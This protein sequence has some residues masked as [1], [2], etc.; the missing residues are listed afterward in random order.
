MKPFGRET[1]HLAARD[2]GLTQNLRRPLTCHYWKIFPEG[3]L[4]LLLHTHI[5]G[6]Y[7]L[8]SS[9]LTV[10]F[11]LL[12]LLST[13]TKNPLEDRNPEA[14]LVFVFSSHLPQTRRKRLDV[15]LC[16]QSSKSLSAQRHCPVKVC[17][18]LSTCASHGP[19]AVWSRFAVIA[20]YSDLVI[21]AANESGST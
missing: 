9:S 18:P 4:L 3:I 12:R 21:S 13:D 19:S 15:C 11:S 8:G 17:V 7:C 6:V 14:G 2:P 1:P 10:Y 16:G 5:L 20:R